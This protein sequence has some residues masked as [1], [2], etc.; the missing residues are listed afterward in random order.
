[1][2][3]QI[4]ICDDEIVFL[5]NLREQVSDL[6]KQKEIEF[7]M[8]SYNNGNKLLEKNR[9]HIFNILFL[10]IEMPQINGIEI[11]EKIRSFNPYVN[12]IFIT[13]RDDLVLNL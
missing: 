1:M 7:T 2:V 11:A 3:L 8:H 9:E 12:I 5:E 10:D 13:N 6:L 4:G